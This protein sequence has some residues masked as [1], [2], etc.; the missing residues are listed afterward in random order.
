MISGSDFCVV[1][2][3]QRQDR[4]LHF[5]DFAELVNFSVIEEKD[6]LKCRERSAKQID[7]DHAVVDK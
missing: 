3:C 6:S 4:C 2:D 7:H 1:V 5:V